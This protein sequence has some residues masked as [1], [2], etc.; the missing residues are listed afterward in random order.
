MKIQIR[1]YLKKKQDPRQSP[2]AKSSTLDHLSTQPRAERR[3][4]GKGIRIL[5]MV[6]KVI[7]WLD[8][9]DE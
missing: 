3:K 5:K 9:C 4:D 7:A 2:K 8:A 6:E 1:T